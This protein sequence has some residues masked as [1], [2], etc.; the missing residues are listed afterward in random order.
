MNIHDDAGMGGD[1]TF[2][3]WIR[4]YKY[5]RTLFSTR[6][7]AEDRWTHYDQSHLFELWLTKCQGLG[8]NWHYDQFTTPGK[9]INA[10]QWSHVAVIVKQINRVSAI[11]LWVNGQHRGG[12]I[13]FVTWDRNIYY[14]DSSS[15]NPSWHVASD[16]FLEDHYSGWIYSWSLWSQALNAEDLDFTSECDKNMS[17]C[18]YCSCRH[19]TGNAECLSDCDWDWYLNT[20]PDDDRRSNYT[21]VGVCEECDCSSGDNR[22]CSSSTCHECTGDC[23]G[24]A[25]TCTSVACSCDYDTNR[26]DPTDS[27]CE[28]GNYIGLPETC[29]LCSAGYELDC[30]VWSAY[31]HDSSTEHCTAC[32]NDEDDTDY[33]NAKCTYP[34]WYHLT[35]PNCTCHNGQYFN[36]ETEKCTDCPEG[37]ISCTSGDVWTCGGCT[38]GWFQLHKASACVKDCPTGS[39]ANEDTG[40]CDDPHDDADTCPDSTTLGT[41]SL[42]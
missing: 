24:S 29:T 17:S 37:C 10:N 40:R 11:E 15:V 13:S 41:V 6:F 5:Q 19:H 32:A 38:T 9:L 4:P 1:W 20:A 33:T 22:G 14:Y 27:N 21:G 23:I 12:G 31:G 35:T 18:H 8:V 42:Y 2:E 16:F 34:R 7:T 26:T 28:V 30:R 39:T 36:E 25:S 3:A